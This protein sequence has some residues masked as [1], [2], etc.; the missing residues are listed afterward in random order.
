MFNKKRCVNC[1]E[2]IN[3][4]YNFCPYCRVPLNQENSEEWGMLG[5]ND[6]VPENNEIQ[7]PLGFNALFKTLMKTLDKQ[8]TEFEKNDFDSDVEAGKPK[9]RKSGVSISINTS[10]NRPPEIKVRKFGEGAKG[11]TGVKTKKPRTISK[12][13]SKKQKEEFKK[14]EKTSPKTNIRRLSDRVIYELKMPGVKEL[15]DVAINQFKESIEIKALGK[16]K[17]YDKIISVG[18]PIKKYKLSEETLILELVEK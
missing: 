17:A 6:F 10:G 12:N 11:K 9:F 18:L 4:E 1:G 3:Q 13:F 15:E 8:F 2:K 5:K 14:L 16:K 7:M